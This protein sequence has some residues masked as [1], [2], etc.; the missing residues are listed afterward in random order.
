MTIR[1][2]AS[3]LAELTD[4]WLAASSQDRRLISAAAAQIDRLLQ[5]DPD[6]QGEIAHRRP[7]SADRP[8]VRCSLPSR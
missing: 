1:W 4:A 8:A 3:A 5:Y 6:R 2:E 7:T